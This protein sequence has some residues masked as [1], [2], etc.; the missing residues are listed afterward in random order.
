[1]GRKAREGDEGG[2]SGGIRLTRAAFIFDFKNEK[3]PS[4]PGRFSFKLRRWLALH[5]AGGEA[6][7]PALGS[8]P[9]PLGHVLGFSGR[10]S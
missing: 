6:V 2:V 8:V 4:E 1:M 9:G 3:R 7:F 5:H 10:A